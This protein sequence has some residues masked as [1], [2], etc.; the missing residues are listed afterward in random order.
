MGDGIRL[1]ASVVVGRD[2]AGG[3]ELLVLERGDRNRFLPG[4]VVFPGGAV[5][6]ADAELAA[7]W[8][9]TPT[10]ATRAAAV[11]ELAEEA[12][13]TLTG[14]GL[15]A[16]SSGELENEPPNPGDLVEIAHWIA[17]AE[18]PVRFDATYFALRSPGGLEPKPDGT[19]TARAWW[20]SVEELL[21]GW[22]EGRVKL[23]WPTYFTMT[24]LAACDSVDQLMSTRIETREPDDGEL[25]FLHRSTFWQ[26]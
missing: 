6:E 23:Y 17:P 21:Q 26:D 10:E 11:R 4:Y 20:A 16:T 18:V 24:R 12:G 1:A 2:G 22:R 19:E 9:G 15:S 8:F 25:E 5:D 14:G 3:L 13:L 7:T